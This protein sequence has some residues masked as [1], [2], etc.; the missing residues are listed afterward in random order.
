[1]R[2]CMYVCRYTHILYVCLLYAC[3][4]VCTYCD[5][6]KLISTTTVLGTS[7]AFHASGTGG[8]WDVVRS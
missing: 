8:Q 1:M 3:M 5:I 7:W 6:N 2:T 4:L